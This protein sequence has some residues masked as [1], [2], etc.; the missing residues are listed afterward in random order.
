M[1]KIWS[2]AIKV[3]GPVG[4]VAAL[5]WFLVRSIYREDV[6]ALFGSEKV[7]ILTLLLIGFLFIGLIS[8]IL[9]YRDTQKMSAV[10]VTPSTKNYKAVIKDSQL[11]GDFVMG[12]KTVNSGK[13]DGK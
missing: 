6:L 3:T 7:F 9:V 1:E 5:V 10:S 8:A 2:T 11:N 13:E 4:V 12:S